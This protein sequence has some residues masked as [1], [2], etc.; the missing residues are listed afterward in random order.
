MNCGGI[1]GYG[2]FVVRGWDVLLLCRVNTFL[3]I[4]YGAYPRVVLP[5]VGY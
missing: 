5:S 4:L 1:S 3:Q 2:G